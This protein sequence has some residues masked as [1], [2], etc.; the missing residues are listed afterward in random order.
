MDILIIHNNS[1]V[2]SIILC[3]PPV[4]SDGYH[5]WFMNRKQ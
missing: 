3:H 5:V 4:A 2:T 1:I